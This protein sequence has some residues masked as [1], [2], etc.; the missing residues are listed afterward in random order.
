MCISVIESTQKYKNYNGMWNNNEIKLNIELI[1]FCCCLY[2]KQNTMD[3]AYETVGQLMNKN[4][5]AWEKL[6]IISMQNS[7]TYCLF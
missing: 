5:D 7:N 2:W 4:S 1:Y 3:V 6:K